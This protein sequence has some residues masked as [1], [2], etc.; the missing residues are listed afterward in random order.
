MRSVLVSLA[1]LILV[2]GCGGVDSTLEVEAA[3][4]EGLAAASGELNTRT[5]QDLLKVAAAPL[6]Y[7]DVNAAARDGYIPLTPCVAAPPG[8]MG[9]HYVNL[10][11]FMAPPNMTKPSGL[12]YE[13]SA[14]RPGQ[15]NLV[16]VEYFQVVFQDGAPYA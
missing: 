1:A 10:N 13:P 5:L 2:T 16:G 8:G 11:L 4:Y 9:V 3:Q 15:L 12:L 6:K 7:A 14:T